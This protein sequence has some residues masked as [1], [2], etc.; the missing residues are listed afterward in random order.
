M[1]RH[2]RL[3]HPSFQYLIHLFP[4]LFSN[5]DPFSFQCKVC[6]LAKHHRASF[7]LQFYNPSEPFSIIPSDLWGPSRVV[8]LLQ[9]M[10]YYSYR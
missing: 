10:V 1:L 3:G 7:P 5:K 4:N 9:K 2:F 8:H 6:K